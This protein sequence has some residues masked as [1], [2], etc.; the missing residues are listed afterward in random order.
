MNTGDLVKCISSDKFEG[1]ITVDKVYKIESIGPF[2]HSN[3]Y[4]ENGGYFITII[5]NDGELFTLYSNRFKPVS[6]FREE[7]LNVLG[8]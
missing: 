4:N 2:I 8:I 5:A 7:K 1:V 3:T 6:E